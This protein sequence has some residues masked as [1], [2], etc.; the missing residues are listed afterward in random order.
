M[1]LFGSKQI[2]DKP[3]EYHAGV[4][5]TLVGLSMGRTLF[6]ADQDRF[7][8]SFASILNL[9]KG[10]LP[11]PAL[12]NYFAIGSGSEYLPNWDKEFVRE[13]VASF[14]SEFEVIKDAFV[15]FT[16]GTFSQLGL[17]QA[18][19]ICMGYPPD[20]KTMTQYAD[21][22]LSLTLDVLADLADKY[23]NDTRNGRTGQIGNDAYIQGVTASV[24]LGLLIICEK[25]TTAYQ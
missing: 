24:M 3:V 23:K 4:V 13:V 17:I 22:V 2:E 9:Y 8:E 10:T 19:I 15:G 16:K 5:A 11:A 6:R 12:P 1:G 21:G 18:I 20:T 7:G 25:K 14:A